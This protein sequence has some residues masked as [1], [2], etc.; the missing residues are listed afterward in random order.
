[1]KR[2][3]I[4][5]I[6]ALTFVNLSHAISFPV[7]YVASAS[8]E[9][10]LEFNGQVQYETT[11]N[12]TEQTLRKVIEDQLDYMVGPMSQSDAL[13]VPKGNHIVSNIVITSKERNILTIS[14]YYRGTIVLHNGAGNIYPIVLPINP[15]KIFEASKVGNDYPCTDEH[16]QTKDDFWYFWTPYRK[17]CNLQKGTDFYVF[18]ANVKRYKNSKLSYPEYQNLPDALGNISVHMFFGMDDPSLDRNPNNSTD[19]NAENYRKFKKYLLKN[20]YKSTKWSAIQVSSIAKTLNGTSPY[21]E[22]IQKGKLIYRLFFGP[23]GIDEDSLA[24]HWFYKDALENASIFMYEGHSG[25]GANLN[26]ES[27]ES[28]LNEKITLSNRYQ[29]YFFNSCTSYRYYNDNYFNRKISALDPKGTK[30]LDILTNGLA[31]TFYSIPY[32]SAALS[33]ALEKALNYASTNNVFVSYQE[34]AKR[35]D[36]NN[37]FGINGDEDN[38][39]PMA[40]KP[41]HIIINDI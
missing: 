14:Y 26:L 34:L 15:R 21:V 10:Y 1:M 20:G 8:T 22:T 28:S 41:P 27:I 29:I 33:M 19:I 35:M 24:F 32:S 18:N 3:I 7:E 13:S 16:Y 11:R 23:T 37:L 2:I 31:T 17:G 30:K 38:E 39:S 4:L 9:A 36:S 40:F 6:L 5:T 12:P 25:L